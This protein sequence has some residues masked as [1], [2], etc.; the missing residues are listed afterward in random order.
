M[1][2]VGLVAVYQ[3]QQKLDQPTNAFVDQAVSDDG[4][5]TTPGEAVTSSS[6]VE[7]VDTPDPFGEATPNDLPKQEEHSPKPLSGRGLSFQEDTPSSGPVLGAT[8]PEATIQTVVNESD[9]PGRLA[10][11]EDPFSTT[12]TPAEAAPRSAP[13]QRTSPA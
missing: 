11:G 5:N 13:T 7:S 4:G 3:A 2:G 12:V 9:E 8:S 10:E 6:L 1:I